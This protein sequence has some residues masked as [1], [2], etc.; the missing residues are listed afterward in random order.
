MHR[1]KWAGWCAIMALGLAPACRSQVAE[2][3]PAADTWW[4][5]SAAQVLTWRAD[6]EA[7]SQDRALEA[8]GLAMADGFLWVASEKYRRLLRIDPRRRYAARVVAVDVLPFSE[9]EGVT[10]RGSTAYLCD[11]AH[12]AVYAVELGEWASGADARVELPARSLALD[13][14]SAE[15]GK[16]GFEGIEVD[17]EGDLYLLLERGHEA[18]GGCVSTIFRLQREGE[19]LITRGAPMTISLEDC[20]WR[21]SGLAMWKGALLALKTQF[22]GSRYE[23]IAIDPES[24]RWRVVLEMTPLLRSLGEQGWGNN[25]EGIAVDADGGLYLVADNAV[26]GTVTASEPPPAAERTLFLRLPP[27]PAAQMGPP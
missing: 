4:D 17:P 10:I 3:A 15:G 7:F 24:G 8:S 18:G 19:R 20:A 27:R 16:I 14:V 2:Q 26:T 21:L 12:A 11:E 23:V 25:V 6:D 13:G 1:T 5:V 22:P 9:L